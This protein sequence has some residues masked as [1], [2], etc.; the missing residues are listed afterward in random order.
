LISSK[1]NIRK[2]K[3]I[4]ININLII[5]YFYINVKISTPG[6]FVKACLSLVYT[7]VQSRVQSAS[8]GNYSSSSS[9]PS[10]KS[11][12][13]GGYVG[14]LSGQGI[15]SVQTGG[16][17]QAADTKEVTMNVID[18]LSVYWK[19]TS[20]GYS[21]YYDSDHIS[22]G[23]LNYSS[24]GYTG[25]LSSIPGTGSGFKGQIYGTTP[26]YPA[27]PYII[28]L[29]LTKKQNYISKGNVTR[30]YSDTRTFGYSQHYTGYATK[31][32]YDDRVYG[33]A[34]SYSGYANLRLKK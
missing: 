15:K 27:K 26:S 16:S 11:Y 13:S 34:Q 22:N 29:Y 3:N 32:A 30:P 28:W 10:S 6:V 24:G 23:S 20:Y 31:P 14:T 4:W 1:S 8:S 17:L 18:T 25:T 19:V 21:S 9:V 12:N 7:P 2:H 5:A 33:Y